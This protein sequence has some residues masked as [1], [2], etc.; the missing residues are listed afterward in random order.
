MKVSLNWLRDF[1]DFS[2]DENA[3]GELLT[4]AGVEVESIETR[5]ASIDKVVVAQIVESNPHPNA[6]RLS[7]CLVD[8]G[9]P[10][11]RQIVCG[12][13]NY[14]IGDKVPLALPG[15]IL[16]GDLKIKVG[17]LRGVESHGMLCSAKEL[18][19][20]DDAD[21]L[22]ILPPSAPVGASLA[23]LFPADTILDVEITPN[24]ADLL[25]HV[26]IAR[27]IAALSGSKLIPRP[28]P[29]L[30]NFPGDS[31][32]L[33]IELLAQE[34]CLFYSGR[35]IS[36][37]KIGPSPDWLRSRLE[38]LGVRSINNVVDVTNFVMLELGQ[39]L[40]A[41]DADKLQDGIV[42]RLARAGERFDAL[43]GRTYELTPTDLLIADHERGVAIAGVMGGEESGVTDATTNIILES[44]YF[45]PTSIRRTSR[46]L[47]LVSESSYRFERGVDPASLLAASERATELIVSLAGGSAHP[48]ENV[49]A[50]PQ[51]ANRVAFRNERCVA[52]MGCDIPEVESHSILISLGLEKSDPGWVVPS[53]RQDLTREIDLIEEV[54]RVFGIEKIPGR[55]MARFAA[56]SPADRAHD[57]RMKT[58]ERLVNRGFYE[59]RTISLVSEKAAASGG[60]I[61]LRNPLGEDQSLLRPSLLPGLFAVLERNARISSDRLRFFEVGRTFH[62]TG[63]E[64]TTSLGIV[65][66]GP[67]RP[68]SWSGAAPGDADFFDLKG[69]IES[70][71]VEEISWRPASDPRFIL[72]AEVL[73]GNQPIGIAGQ[74]APADARKIGVSSVILAAELDLHFSERNTVRRF[75][76]IEKFP[77]V[78]RDIAMIVP[79][80]TA[81][82]QIA[83]VISEANEPLLS[84]CDV[85][86]FFIDP[87]GDKVS[88][89]KK[90]LAYSLTYRSKDRTLTVD[91]VNAVH[92]RLKERLK[93][94]LDVVF[95]E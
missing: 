79:I 81:H 14:K 60:A 36:G 27:E 24:R 25:S 87:E 73:A 18:R 44:A 34:Q 84:R 49:G 43:D 38:S 68:S 51:T 70:L 92:T 11:R 41:F 48:A 21:G 63:T 10:E 89:G 90:S 88:A 28:R 5:G 62:G 2:H 31:S 75:S 22:L 50:I 52:L 65:L 1:V 82:E 61:R 17:K 64:E 66:A 15:A 12:A 20:A 35:K 29:A 3:I 6:D 55:T 77:A 45:L 40:H 91:E 47:D 74:L 59:A 69:V 93:A 54:V 19:L 42:V 67:R 95:R 86:D 16:P 39:P 30:R 53:Y 57:W 58:R 72:A 23:E 78:T 9:S 37:V 83:G 94:E 4:R 71:G 33:K 46:R 8:D 56:H 32:G 7:V 80:A 13:K 85:F 26:G 76:E